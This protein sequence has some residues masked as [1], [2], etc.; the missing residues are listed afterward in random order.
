M[1]KPT[2]IGIVVIGRNEGE[3]L[4]RCLQSLP[5]DADCVY[6][7]SGSH[8]GSQD[9]ARS[10]GLDVVDLP[11]DTGFTAARARN[12]GTARIAAL[13]NPPVYVQMLDGDCELRSGWIDAA[14][15]ALSAEPRLAAVFGRLRERFPDVSPYNRMCDEEWNVPVGLVRSCSGNAMFR[16]APLTQSGGYDATLIAGEEIDLCLRIAAAGWTFRRIDADMALHDVAMLHFSQWWQRTR[17]AGFAFAEH[18]WRRRGAADSDWKHAL[19]RIIFWALLL[20]FVLIMTLLSGHIFSQPMFCLAALV[21]AALY[22]L[23]WVRVA[24]RSYAT[25][26]DAGY[27]MFCS[28]LSSLD[29]FAQLSGAVQFLTQKILRRSAKI[30]EHKV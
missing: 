5:A 21:I 25:N 22:P 24:L 10:L 3:R 9:F 15:E 12:A 17:R 14:V 30:I 20:P 4:K 6:V 11:M 26:S 27:A 1:K 29:K 2:R 28:A 19:L 23:Q 7:D 8:D 18:V 13:P 16:L